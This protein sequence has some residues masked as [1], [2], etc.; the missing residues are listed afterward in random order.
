MPSHPL[1]RKLIR[2]AGVPLAAP[3][4]NPFGYVSPTSAEHVLRSLGSKIRHILDGGPSRIGLESTIIDLRDPRRPA[5]L[6]PGAITR[7]AVARVLGVPVAAR[8]KTRGRA[9]VAPGQLA[10]HYSPRTPVKLH[11]RITP[12]MPWPRVPRTRRGSL[13]QGRPSRET[14]QAR[15]NVFWLD[16]KGDL[17][18]ASRRLF[19]RAARA[20]RGGLQ[21]NPRRTARRGRTRRG[22]RRPAPARR[23]AL[24][25]RAPPAARQG[26]ARSARA[27]RRSH[28]STRASHS[29]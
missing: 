22:P 8:R 5:L 3:S 6:R 16:A 13:S 27:S 29:S 24:I 15:A 20:G 1:F 4:A 26:N 28:G 9:Q 17:V 2:L 19:R 18:R 23:G 25:S 12:R 10:R 14:P 11:A 21:A 7:A